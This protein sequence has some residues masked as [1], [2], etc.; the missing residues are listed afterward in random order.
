MAQNPQVAIDAGLKPVAI[1]RRGFVGFGEAIESIHRGGE[2]AFGPISNDDAPRFDDG[3][4]VL[5]SPVRRLQVD[6]AGMEG[7]A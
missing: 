7:E 5:H 4:E 2:V 1:G 3:A 6:L